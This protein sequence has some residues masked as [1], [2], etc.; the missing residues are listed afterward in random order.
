M[1]DRMGNVHVSVHDVYM[2]ERS[3]I[4]DLHYRR[5]PSA[6]YYSAKGNIDE[7]IRDPE[8]PSAC[9]HVSALHR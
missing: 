2:A 8:M 7:L 6:A 9:R 3:S 4:R 1:R 5:K